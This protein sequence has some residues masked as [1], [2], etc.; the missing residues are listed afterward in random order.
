MQSE[1]TASL[2]ILKLVR[3]IQAIKGFENFR[4]VGG[5]ALALQ[6]KHRV[7]VDVALF[8][9][10]T[11]DKSRLFAILPENFKDLSGLIDRGIGVVCNIKNI[12]VDFFY[13]GGK[14]I[15]PPVEKQGI[16]MA[17]LEDVTAMKLN[18]ITNRA[19]QKDFYDIAVLTE[20]F[21]V[22]EMIRFYM[23]KYPYMDVRGPLEHLKKHDAADNDNNRIQTLIPLTWQQAKEKINNAHEIF[24]SEMKAEKQKQI[25]ERLKKAG[26]L[27]EKKKKKKT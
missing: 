14:F 19:A 1:E 4:L 21:S 18:A 20:K 13:D 7:S 22:R 12:K 2:H 9:E 24:I 26:E 11:I 6:L 23:E 10:K 8:S 3:E 27:V 15:R 25:E 16:I 17:S 5:S